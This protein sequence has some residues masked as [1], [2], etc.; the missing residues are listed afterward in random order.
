M[1]FNLTYLVVSRHNVHS[2]SSHTVSIK[3]IDKKQTKQYVL[4]GIGA[5]ISTSSDTFYN[6]VESRT[7]GYRH[8]LNTIVS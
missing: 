5:G 8:I 1:L 7:T 2:I 4:Q 3:Q 6:C